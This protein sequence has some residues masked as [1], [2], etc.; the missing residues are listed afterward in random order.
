M[1]RCHYSDGPFG[2]LHW[3]ERPGENTDAPVL[4]CLHPAPF[5]SLFFTS[6]MPLIDKRYRVVAADYPG[7]GGSVPVGKEATIE[8][9]SEAMLSLVHE[10]SPAGEVQ[11]LGFHTGCLVAVEM[12]LQAP[13]LI[14]G[15]TLIDVP[16][17][18]GKAREEML[19]RAAQPLQL[20]ED[21]HSVE[22]LW[23][24]AVAAKLD[25][26]PLPRAVEL[27]AEQ[28]RVSENSHF[29]FRAAFSYCCDVQMARMQLPV[30]V[31]ATQS[32]LLQAT[33][34]CAQCIP[35]AQ[36]VERLDITRAVFEKGAPQI[37]ESINTLLQVSKE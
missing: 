34:D 22:G 36:L 9:Y 29:A 17:S 19:E 16:Y 4:M 1:I 32:F 37:S 5:S 27:L 6:V 2:Q 11:V 35:G 28:L 14:A 7:Y 3:R 25:A 31:I 13:H 12:A 15:L 33:R 10:L 24:S 18:T 20:N 21:V 8:D 26:M 23:K 30:T